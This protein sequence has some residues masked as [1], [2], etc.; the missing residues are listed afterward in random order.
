MVNFRGFTIKN[1]DALD[2]KGN[3]A[4]KYRGYII[5]MSTI[6]SDNG[7]AFW[8]ATNPDEYNDA[9]TVE[10]AILKIDNLL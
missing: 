6:F 5:S 8:P 10:D 7:V 2:I 9:E 4:F 3:A 1:I